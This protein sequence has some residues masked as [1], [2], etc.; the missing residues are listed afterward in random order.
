MPPYISVII[1][2]YN[3][4]QYVSEAINS[5]LTQT[6]DKNKYEII[7]ISNVDLP[8]REGVKITKSKDPTLGGKVVEGILN[9]EG[10]I[11]SLLEDDDLFS[12][13]KLEVVYVTFKRYNISLFHNEMYFID[14]NGNRR[15]SLEKKRE[16]TVRKYIRED[17]VSYTFLKRNLTDK[18]KLSF[19]N[20]S[21]SFRK[22]ALLPYLDYIKD[23]KHLGLDTIIFF[24]AAYKNNLFLSPQKL[25]CY[26][27]HTSNASKLFIDGKINEKIV[28]DSLE[29][30]QLYDRLREVNEFFRI[31]AYDSYLYMR[32]FESEGYS[33]S[34]MKALES[35]LGLVK[36]D[37]HS[38]IRFYT[39]IRN[40]IALLPKPIRKRL[41]VEIAK[42]IS[43]SWFSRLC[44][45]YF[46]TTLEFLQQEEEVCKFPPCIGNKDLVENNKSWPC[47]N[48]LALAKH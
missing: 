31:I 18:I 26:R 42:R 28:K 20:S 44:L 19:N 27:V 47:M 7:V 3:R 37:F 10:E 21:I 32:I 15:E 34:F 24:L 2:V 45:F 40:L 46:W 22:K 33:T 16:E 39:L 1:P 4:T 36:E 41:A 29:Q 38:A 48:L 43:L 8:E 5:V 14:E 30:Y 6:L 23:I 25:T 9:S 13:N 11:I 12:T 17:P 35:V